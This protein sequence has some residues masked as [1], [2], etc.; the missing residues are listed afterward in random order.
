MKG[1]PVTDQFVRRNA[2]M[3]QLEKFFGSDVNADRKR[4]KVLVV[5]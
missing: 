5:Q 2:E 4:Q 1:L 3:L